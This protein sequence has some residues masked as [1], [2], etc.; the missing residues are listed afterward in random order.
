MQLWIK[1]MLLDLW[2]EAPHLHDLGQL[3]GFAL[4]KL[5]ASGSEV[6]KL[7]EKLGSMRRDLWFLSESYYEA[8]YEEVEYL[9]EDAERCIAM[10]GAL[11]DVIEDSE[12][13]CARRSI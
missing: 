13:G 8:R 11:R 3:L 12:K 4:K 10:A 6:D 1:C 9:K 5:L 7:A 2:N